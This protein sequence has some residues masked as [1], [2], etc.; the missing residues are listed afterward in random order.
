[1]LLAEDI[2]RLEATSGRLIVAFSGGCDSHTLLH[3]LHTCLRHSVEAIHVNHG[4]SSAADEWQIHCEAIC[5]ALGLPLTSFRVEVKYLRPNCAAMMCSSW[6]I[7][8][9]IR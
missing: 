6:G 7:I 3:L 9:T 8:K 4:L 2:A 1:M 5:D